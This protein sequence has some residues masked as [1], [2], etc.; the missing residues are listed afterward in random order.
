MG[1]KRIITSIQD[2]DLEP[3]CKELG[4]EDTIIPVRTMSQHLDNIIEGFDNIELSTL[5]KENSRLFSFI[6]SKEDEGP[7]DDLD[8]PDG[9]RV[10]YYYRDDE[11]F[12][13]EEETKIHKDDEIVILTD[14]KHLSDLIER[15]NPKEI[16]R[17][18]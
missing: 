17:E 15:W 13:V 4:L 8:L 16:N 14:S 3:L 1:F 5:L 12:F 10:I 18:D 2:E 7:I 9:S 11:F 6:A